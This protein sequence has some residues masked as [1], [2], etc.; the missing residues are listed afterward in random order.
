MSGVLYTLWVVVGRHVRLVHTPCSVHGVGCCLNLTLVSSTVACLPFPVQQQLCLIKLDARSEI[1]TQTWKTN[2]LIS[3][4]GWGWDELG[5]R[6]WHVHTIM[7]SESESRSVVSD[8]L[9][10]HGLYSPWSSPGQHSGAG[11]LSLLQE[12]FPT[13][14]SNRGNR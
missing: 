4:R 13:Q 9:W 1:E 12:V 7:Y 14:G 5:D 10:P 3:R 6:D 8:S 11:N 2:L